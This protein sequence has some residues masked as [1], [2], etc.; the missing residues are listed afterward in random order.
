VLSAVWVQVAGIAFATAGIAATV[1]AQ[2]QMGDSWR[3]GVDEQEST[4]LVHSGVFGLVRNPI[5]TS[6]F[7]FGLGAA[8]L[9][10]NLLACAGFLLLVASI[11]LQVRRAEEPYLLRTHGDAYR[12]Y[13][14]K[15]GRFVP[16]V[17][18]IR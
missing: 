13:G 8:L 3:I 4:A 14:A 2:L 15:V 1:S 11:E 17:G 12:T 5:Y 7:I 9:T 10:P 18:V 6:M 16:R